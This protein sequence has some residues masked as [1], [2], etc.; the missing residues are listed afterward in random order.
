[1]MDL[2]FSLS[3]TC[4]PLVKVCFP[5]QIKSS[6]LICF[7][8]IVRFIIANNNASLMQ[9]FCYV[10]RYSRINSRDLIRRI[11]NRRIILM[12]FKTQRS[13]QI[14]RLHSFHAKAETDLWN[15]WKNL[16]RS[17]PSFSRLK[18]LGLPDSPMRYDIFLDADFQKPPCLVATLYTIQMRQVSPNFSINST[19]ACCFVS[20]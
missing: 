3:Q 6:A 17:S 11:M 15:E 4:T 19:A 5:M 13:C 9:F 1:M 2:H 18:G 16:P 8:D 10:L 14:T 12:F 7:L 20:P